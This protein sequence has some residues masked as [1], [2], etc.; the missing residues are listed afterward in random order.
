[1]NKTVYLHVNGNLVI[2]GLSQD[3]ESSPLVVKEF[4][5]DEKV[6]DSEDFREIIQMHNDRTNEVKQAMQ[7]SKR[8]MSNYKNLLGDT[9]K[10]FGIIKLGIN[11]RSL[12]GLVK[13]SSIRQFI[14]EIK[15]IYEHTFN[16][17]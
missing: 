4:Q 3:F 1:M 15:N 9:I 2:W 8:A 7:L 17:F 10:S 6:A 16:I 11:N 14:D 13:V 12:F 5:I